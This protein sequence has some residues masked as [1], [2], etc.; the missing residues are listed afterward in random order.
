MSEIISTDI[1]CSLLSSLANVFSTDNL[2]KQFRSSSGP[3][4]FHAHQR[5]TNGT[6]RDSVHTKERLMAQAVILINCA[7]FI[8]RTSL[9]AEGSDLN[10]LLQGAK[11]F[12]SG[13][14][15]M[16]GKAWFPH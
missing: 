15:P 16:F 12:L 13:Q 1:K 2:S 5:E 9:I 8:N 3:V 10:S 7:L 4:K 6:D 11:S 14:S